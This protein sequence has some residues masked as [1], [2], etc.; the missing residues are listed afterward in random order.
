MQ[1]FLPGFEDY[2]HE[3]DI[4]FQDQVSDR[5]EQIADFLMSRAN[6]T[7]LSPLE[8]LY[9][10]G[11]ITRDEHG[12]PDVSRIPPD[13]LEEVAPTLKYHPWDEPTV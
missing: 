7:G 11:I 2:D 9:T 13:P 6:Q 10:S 3:L 12:L 8:L 4:D 1:L 5:L